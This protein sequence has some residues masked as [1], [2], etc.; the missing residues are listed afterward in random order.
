MLWH[1]LLGCLVAATA[2]I[3]ETAPLE[4]QGSRFFHSASGEQF[5]LKGLHYSLNIDNENND[6]DD[7]LANPTACKR[8]IPYFKSLGINTISVYTVDATKDHDECMRLLADAG[9]Y[10]IP[11]LHPLNGLSTGNV[12]WTTA[13]FAAQTAIVDAF[14]GYDNLLAFFFQVDS[15]LSTQRAAG[16]GN[17]TEGSALFAAYAKSVV[18]DVKAYIASEGR[19]KYQQ[20][21]VGYAAH[22]TELIN[23]E[24]NYFTCGDDAEER[25]DIL[26]IRSESWCAG[27]TFKSSGWEGL[28]SELWYPSVPIV[29]AEY[30]CADPAG[31]DEEMN[32]VA[33][34]YGDDMVVDWSGGMYYTY[35]GQ[36]YGL[37]EINEDKVTKSPAFDTFASILSSSAPSTQTSGPSYSPSYY[38][39][40]DDPS[41]FPK[42]PPHPDEQ[43]CDCTLRHNLCTTLSNSPSA[44][45]ALWADICSTSKDLCRRRPN[46]NDAGEYGRYSMCNASVELGALLSDRRVDDLGTGAGTCGMKWGENVGYN[47]LYG[48]W[49]NGRGPQ[50]CVHVPIGADP[51]GAPYGDD[52]DEKGMCVCVFLIV[53]GANL[54]HWIASHSANGV[55]QM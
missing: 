17:E 6:T 31:R 15:S 45:D 34:L 24:I 23:D 13:D 47:P 33:T 48:T 8:D 10:V 41:P 26:G 9:I 38:T 5:I 14:T 32:D 51:P 37:V 28:T 7:P 49:P 42:Q 19:G 39:T 11:Y 53:I 29:M 21:P 3:G 4:R 40:C 54:L 43:F 25:V 2:V 27:S 12:T 50:K 22:L 55:L 52:E 20:I 35:A 18:R 46:D 44:L 30:Y 36:D 1:F 16:N